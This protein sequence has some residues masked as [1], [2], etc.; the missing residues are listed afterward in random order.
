MKN[1]IEIASMILMLRES[2]NVKDEMNLR[3]HLIQPLS[4]KDAETEAQTG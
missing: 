3:G 1:G 4:L 2:W